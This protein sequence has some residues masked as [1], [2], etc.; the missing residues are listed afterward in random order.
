MIK[1]RFG[2]AEEM[3]ISYGFRKIA[4]E[5]K[6][7]MVNNVFSRV[8]YRYDVMNDFM[9]LGLHRFWKEAMVSA[10]NPRKSANY[11]VLDVAG[12]TGDI[13]FRIAESSDFKSHIVV[14]DINKEMLS[15]GKERAFKEKLQN[16]ITFVE[17]DA[18]HLPFESSSFSACT[19][20]FGIRNMPRIKLVLQE[21]YRILEYGGRLL[22]L[23]F[24]EVQYPILNK[25]YDIWSFQVI[26]HIGKLVAGDEEPYRYLVESIRR[27]PNQ[28]DFSAMIAD[29]GFSNISV[30]NYT[31]GI[32][33][34][35][36]GWKF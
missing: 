12:G 24:S 36:S 1:D 8:A 17:A 3:E 4:A 13:A 9:S 19:L 10:L 18:E 7:G 33:A 26:P 35:H 32:V 14:A 6:Q 16:N 15:I 11:R 28:Q 31:G 2:S 23:E 29:S 30:K 5:D 27:F 20:A 25:I 22:I 34:L 21:I